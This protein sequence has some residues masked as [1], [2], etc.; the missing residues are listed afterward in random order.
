MAL[1]RSHRPAPRRSSKSRSSEETTAA[2]F[3]N[4]GEPWKRDG[5][6]P[7][8]FSLAEYALAQVDVSGENG[9]KMYEEIIF[10]IFMPGS[11]FCV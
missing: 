7:R 1:P 3:D 11:S 10:Y 6:G 2:L 4:V 8:F 9:M 5:N